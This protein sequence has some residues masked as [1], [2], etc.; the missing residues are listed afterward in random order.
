MCLNCGPAVSCIPRDTVVVMISDIYVGGGKGGGGENYAM[1]MCDVTVH[2]S[3]RYYDERGDIKS[4][5]SFDV[6]F[7]YD[8]PEPPGSWALRGDRV[9]THGLNMYVH[10]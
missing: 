5:S 7:K 6:L 9:V 3:H 10:M 4:E 2:H 1:L 8:L